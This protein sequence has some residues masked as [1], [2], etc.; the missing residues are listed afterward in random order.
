MD[1]KG[2]IMWGDFFKGFIFGLVV[3]AII[4][5][6]IVNGFIPFPLDLCSLM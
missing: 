3:T 4:F 2:F 1:K 6:L 5:I